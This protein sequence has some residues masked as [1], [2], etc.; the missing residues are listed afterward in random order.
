MKLR[1]DNFYPGAGQILLVEL[2]GESRSA[3]NLSRQ[4]HL[5]LLLYEVSSL[6]RKK[7]VEARIAN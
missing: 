5:S 3:D 7:K 4:N 1:L 6:Q 2:T